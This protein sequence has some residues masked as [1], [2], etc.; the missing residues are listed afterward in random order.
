MPRATVS[1]LVACAAMAV[2]S[3]TPTTAADCYAIFGSVTTPDGAGLEGVR[4]SP[5]GGL[6]V[7]VTGLDG[8]YR[9]EGALS[10]ETYA[11]EATLPGYA[12]VPAKRVVVVASG[13]EQVDFVASEINSG[14]CAVETTAA[15]PG[16]AVSPQPVV[17]Y[18]TDTGIV[19][20]RNRSYN[21]TWGVFAGA[22]V[23]I[24]LRRN[25]TFQR[26]ISASTP[27]DG[28]FSWLIPPGL[29][30]RS[31]YRIRISSTSTVT[32]I[33]LSDHVFRVAPLA[34]V[35][36][37]SGPGLEF[38]R[39]IPVTITW[40]NF[41]GTHV[42]I[43]NYASGVFEGQLTA[44]T[45]NDGSYTAD[46]PFE[47]H[48]ASDYRIHITSVGAPGDT[49]KSNNDF[50]V[51][52]N[53][54]VVYPSTWGIAWNRGSH[55]SIKWADIAGPHVK[56]RLYKGGVL[57]RTISA[58][59]PNDGAFVWSV[60][61]G[62]TPG[63]DYKIRVN[64]TTVPE[65]DW[66]NNPFEIAATPLVIY[67]N[68]SG[69]AVDHGSQM[70]I[71]W[72][73]FPPGNVRIELLRWGLPVQLLKSSTANDGAFMWKV[74]PACSST[75]NGYRVRIS[76]VPHPTVSDT[77]DGNFTITSVP[78]VVYPNTKLATYSR[79]STMHIGWR[80]FSG[81]YVKIELLRSGVVERVIAG[82]ADNDDYHTWV[83]PAPTPVASDYRIRI[84]SVSAPTER[85]ASDYLFSID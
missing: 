56:I 81:L 60:P 6:G 43:E 68:A 46:L 65:S 57:S 29:A 42:K 4:V 45:P 33:D 53:P 47:A 59:T 48:L 16:L 73:D 20:H 54:R 37:P 5:S 8:S 3:A 50:S 64:S 15:A 69:T 75:G 21:I 35:L 28:S 27:N 70:L 10:G 19:W 72:Q 67:P 58:A 12:F 77:S 31:D 84:T 71:Q 23:R 80:G 7:T 41:T 78:I 40:Q 83:P 13:D 49:D 32:D 24:E 38:P 9:V 14:M 85:D 55:Y 44:S 39:G 17:T 76:S 25:W 61:V 82:T 22:N 34:K 52:A 63:T 62:Q 11:V 18:P 26:L 30:Y 66:S 79:G 1:I 51:V 2:L 36:F 74:L